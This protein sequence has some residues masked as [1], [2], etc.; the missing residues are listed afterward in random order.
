M[1]MESSTRCTQL[2]LGAEAHL[3]PSRRRC[4]WVLW[5][6]LTGTVGHRL[7][8]VDPGV[9]LHG[10]PGRL[11]VLI[12]SSSFGVYGCATAKDWRAL[13][14]PAVDDSGAEILGCRSEIVWA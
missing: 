3:S 8:Q 4:L 5:S 14:L 2:G 7:P 10:G 12:I 6:A 1:I 13:T 11:P 9:G